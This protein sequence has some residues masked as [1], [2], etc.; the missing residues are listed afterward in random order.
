MK[1]IRGACDNWKDEREEARVACEVLMSAPY[2]DS[3]LLSHHC[4]TRLST[5]SLH[6]SLALALNINPTRCNPMLTMTLTLTLKAKTTSEVLRKENKML[7]ME[8]ERKP[9]RVRVR[10]SVT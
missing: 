3:N 9:S 6:L 10:H 7:T 5:R 8:C 2:P 1:E 4:H